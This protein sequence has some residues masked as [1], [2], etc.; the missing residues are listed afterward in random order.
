M[1]SLRRSSAEKR[2]DSYG[3]RRIFHTE[4]TPKFFRFAGEL[5]GLDDKRVKNKFN[6]LRST[7]PVGL[8]FGE[9]DLFGPDNSWETQDALTYTPSPEYYRAQ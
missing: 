2:V 9:K 1:A 4:K 5:F 6:V 8:G 7:R 3:Y